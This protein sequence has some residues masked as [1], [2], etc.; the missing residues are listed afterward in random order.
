ML[1]KIKENTSNNL[2]EFIKNTYLKTEEE[3]IENII[4]GSKSAFDNI[5][6][7][8]EEIK[9]SKN[10]RIKYFKPTD[11]WRKLVHISEN[12]SKSEDCYDEL[13][14]GIEEYASHYYHE[15]EKLNIV[16]DHPDLLN[17]VIDRYVDMLCNPYIYRIEGV[18]TSA[19]L[20]TFRK[21]NGIIP[22]D[23]FQIDIKSYVYIV[24]K[25]AKHIKD[26]T[27]K[28]YINKNNE[29]SSEEFLDNDIYE[30]IQQLILELDNVRK[31]KE[32]L[33]NIEYTSK[34]PKKARTR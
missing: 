2:K 34:T 7:S 15:L 1:N 29:N 33:T 21:A 3:K 14:S 16:E 6:K 25:I 18:I 9:N 23:N 24:S 10:Y 22:N 13:I 19:D 11:L 8:K 5:V 27:V 20:K 12:S 4:T 30:D 32:I 26:D 31:E 28:D 17:A